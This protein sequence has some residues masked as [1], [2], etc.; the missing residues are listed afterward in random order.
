MALGLAHQLNGPD[1]VARPVSRA[2]WWALY[3]TATVLLIRY[4]LVVPLRQALRHRLRVAAVHDESPGVVSILIT[5]RDLRELGAAPGQFFRWR[6]LDQGLW[7]TARPYSLSAAPQD[8]MLRITVK[9]AGAHSRALAGVRPGTRVLAQGPYGSLTADPL[10]ARKVLLLGGGSGI[11]PLRALLETL[12]GEITLIYR[13]R[14]AEDLALR[15]ELDAIAAIRGARVIYAVDGPGP[16]SL[17]LT[18][19]A[20]RAVIPHLAAHTVYLTGPPG[21]TAA[22]RRALRRAGVPRRNVRCESFDF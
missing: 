13:A 10:P 6:F 1:M 22:A 5:G 14:R 4:R 18:G 12:P 11:A 15:T 9:C 20:L 19:R 3:A 17:P 21:M 8:S 7:R 16:V 2:A